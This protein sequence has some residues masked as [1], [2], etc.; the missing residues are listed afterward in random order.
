[1]QTHSNKVNPLFVIHVITVLYSVYKQLCG[2]M[3]VTHATNYGLVITVYTRLELISPI[4]IKLNKT[5]RI[6]SDSSHM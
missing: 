3:F 6:Q 4:I 2:F 1:M 5:V